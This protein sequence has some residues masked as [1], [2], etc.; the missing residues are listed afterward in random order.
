MF[1]SH[2]QADAS[3]HVPKR[4]DSEQIDSKQDFRLKGYVDLFI[5][6]INEEVEKN[7]SGHPSLVYGIGDAWKQ[8]SNTVCPQKNRITTYYPH[9]PHQQPTGSGIKGGDEGSGND[10]QTDTIGGILGKCSCI[11]REDGANDEDTSDEEDKLCCV[12]EELVIASNEMLRSWDGFD[13]LQKIQAITNMCRDKVSLPKKEMHRRT[14]VRN[15]LMAGLDPTP[16]QTVQWLVRQFHLCRC[17]GDNTSCSCHHGVSSFKVC[18]VIL[19]LP[20][21]LDLSLS[22]SNVAICSPS[23]E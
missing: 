18:C 20:F 14:A 11:G 12:P 7:A 22:V 5:E 23:L 1:V 16:L 17:S 9:Q 19:L 10:E 21:I 4:N 8:N 3:M 15:G 13:L 6:T 2:H